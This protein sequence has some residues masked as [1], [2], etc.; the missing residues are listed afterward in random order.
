M[1]V[2]HGNGDGK[3]VFLTGRVLNLMR[4][5]VVIRRVK[6]GDVIRKSDIEWIEIEARRVRDSIVT[7]AESLIGQQ[8]VRTLVAGKP[9][10]NRDVRSRVLVSKGSLATL[11]L[12]T[13]RM[14]LTVRVLAMSDGG[15]GE[16]IRVLNT[17]S[18]KIIEGV[19]S[20]PGRI[21]VPALGVT[22]GS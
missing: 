14:L 18:K 3:Q 21:I 7:D 10:R 16:T 8:V 15:M 11:T 2:P 17:R 1:L 12:T 20:G 9:V 5:P 22:Q 4:V 13:N 19:V 6:I